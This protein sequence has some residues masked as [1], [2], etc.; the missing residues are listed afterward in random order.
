MNLEPDAILIGAKSG[1]SSQVGDHASKLLQQLLQ[2]SCEQDILNEH[3]RRLSRIH[4]L[5][6]A[7]LATSNGMQQ[8]IV[9]AA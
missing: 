2:A 3:F 9:S 4:T 5:P 8:P 1:H 6:I 7:V